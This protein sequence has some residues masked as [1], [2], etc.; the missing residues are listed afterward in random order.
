[1][2]RTTNRTKR[3]GQQRDDK[4]GGFASGH[5]SVSSSRDH[6]GLNRRLMMPEESRRF[7]RD[8]YVFIM[9]LI[10]FAVFLVGGSLAGF[11]SL[12]ILLLR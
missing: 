11:I 8:L 7:L 5:L 9:I 4:S 12:A 10:V 3:L 1:M 6:L 2:P